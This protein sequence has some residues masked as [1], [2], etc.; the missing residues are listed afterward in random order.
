MPTCSQA[1]IIT[2]LESDINKRANILINRDAELTTL[3]RIEKINQK[4]QR[5]YEQ[6]RSNLECQNCAH[7]AKANLT[8]RR[9]SIQLKSSRKLPTIINNNATNTNNVFLAR[10]D[11]VPVNFLFNSTYRNKSGGQQT[12]RLSPTKNNATHKNNTPPNDYEDH[13]DAPTPSTNSSWYSSNSDNCVARN[14]EENEESCVQPEFIKRNPSNIFSSLPRLALEIEQIDD[15]C[16]DNTNSHDDYIRDKKRF[17]ITGAKRLLALASIRPSR[18]FHKELTPEEAEIL[19]RY[20]EIL[21]PK[22]NMGLNLDGDENSSDTDKQQKAIELPIFYDSTKISY[23][24]FSCLEMFLTEY[25]TEITSG[26]FQIEYNPPG[27]AGF[28]LK[29][30]ET[31]TVIEFPLHVHD[32]FVALAMSNNGN[33][34]FDENH[35][36]KSINWNDT[37]HIL[38]PKKFRRKQSKT[39]ETKKFVPSV[40][41]ESIR[42]LSRIVRIVV[43][44]KLLKKVTESGLDMR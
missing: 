35:I 32:T 14:N 23:D 34:N 30:K 42:D 39:F 36:L 20:F 13:E 15:S 2:N 10:R 31:D 21:K 17:S 33:P 6:K 29:N 22:V 44:P 19:K 40:N 12:T 8:E 4:S 28:V 18:T 3:T 26:K 24:T 37:R 25:K 5:N 41:I 16:S 1:K 27:Y 9:G 7:Q 43:E 11:S 38:A